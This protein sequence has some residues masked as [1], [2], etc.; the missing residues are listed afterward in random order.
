MDSAASEACKLGT[1]QLP[2][3]SH[4]HNALAELTYYLGRRRA[5]AVY[6]RFVVFIN[7][8]QYCFDRQPRIKDSG[9]VDLIIL[10]A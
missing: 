5:H 1:A 3:V 6:Y 2:L 8:Q 4:F 10:L 7:P 9:N